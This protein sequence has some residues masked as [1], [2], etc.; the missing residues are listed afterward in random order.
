MN[1]ETNPFNGLLPGANIRV[2]KLLK[3]HL[4]TVTMVR[5]GR[6]DNP[7]VENALLNELEKAVNMREK[8]QTRKKDL[9]ERS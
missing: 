5:Q 2:A 7:R 6:T 3:V 8:N 9:A 1:K 4:N